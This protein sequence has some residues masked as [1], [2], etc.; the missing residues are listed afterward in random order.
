MSPSLTDRR[1]HFDFGANWRAYAK[2]IDDFRFGKA[3]DGLLRL[4]PA[5]LSN[6]TFLDIGCGSGLHAAAAIKLGAISVM[7]TDLDEDSVET[8]QTTLAQL[9]SGFAWSVDRVSVF[10]LQDD[11][12]FDVVYSWGVLHHTGDMWRAIDKAAKLVKPGGRLAIAIYDRTPMD[13]FWIREKSL[14]SRSPAV[15]Q[16]LVRQVYMAAYLLGKMVQGKSPRSFL[17]DYAVNRGMNFVHDAH[18]WL[19]G[20]PYE[21]ATASEINERLISL[22]FAEERSFILPRGFGLFGAGCNEFVFKK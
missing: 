17:K 14:Y 15:V 5:G 9:T 11:R 22:G 10:D 6:Q 18:D 19:G 2:T 1:S 16:G 3:V 8:T 4:F 12:Q 7:A 20:Y 21:P 13:W